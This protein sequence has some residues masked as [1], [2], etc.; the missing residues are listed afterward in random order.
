MSIAMPPSASAPHSA[1]RAAV[2]ERPK[3]PNPTV[4][5]AEQQWMFSDDEL[6][7]TPSIVDGMTPEAEREARKKGANFILQ[8]GMLLKLPQTTLSTACVFFNRYLMRMSLVT[9]DGYKPLHHYVS[10]AFHLEVNHRL[11]STSKLL[12]PPYSSPPKSKRIAAK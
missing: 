11:T 4:V 2:R 5:E 12:P 9:R 8:V 7:R 10:N 6:L 3:P 1:R